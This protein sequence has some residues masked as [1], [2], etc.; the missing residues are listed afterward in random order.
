MGSGGA[1]TSEFEMETGGAMSLLLQIFSNFKTDE[2]P[3]NIRFL[4]LGD[5]LS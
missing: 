3:Q 5:R 2:S 4:T 1:V